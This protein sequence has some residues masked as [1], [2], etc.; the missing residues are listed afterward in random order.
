MATLA[1]L[2]LSAD[3]LLHCGVVMEQGH[4][5]CPLRISGLLPIVIMFGG[6]LAA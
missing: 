3:W 2:S 4:V 5:F 1:L 6:V